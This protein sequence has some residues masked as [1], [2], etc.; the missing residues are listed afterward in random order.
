MNIKGKIAVI[1]GKTLPK[2]G[3]GFKLEG[4]DG[5]YTAVKEVVFYLDKCVVGDLVDVTY[6]KNKIYKNVTKIVKVSSQKEEPQV[7]DVPEFTCEDCGVALKDGKYKK[8]YKCNKKTNTPPKEDTYKKEDPQTAK[9]R[10]NFTPSTKDVQIRRGNSLAAAGNVLKG[11]YEG[12]NTDIETIKQATLELA[13]SFVNWL[14][15]E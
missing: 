4:D 6:E 7:Q 11:N 15:M 8:C 12:T 1:A 3:K 14:V 5:W 9:D 10:D 13:N 2:G